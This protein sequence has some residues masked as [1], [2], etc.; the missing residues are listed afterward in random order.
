MLA[1]VAPTRTV[2][3][4]CCVG[5]ANGARCGFPPNV[6]RDRF[7]SRVDI[8]VYSVIVRNWE[9]MD[10]PFFAGFFTNIF[11][12]FLGMQVTLIFALKLWILLAVS[13]F[14]FSALFH[15]LP[16][17]FIKHA[18]FV[19]HLIEFFLSLEFPIF[20]AL[21][22]VFLGSNSVTGTTAHRTYSGAFPDSVVRVFHHCQPVTQFDP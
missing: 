11:Q 4:S 18:N 19:L 17:S 3:I 7:F 8:V 22:Y 13:L 2:D 10:R 14:V 6:Q 9:I 1:S 5:L 20:F 12:I 21:R 16:F 15:F